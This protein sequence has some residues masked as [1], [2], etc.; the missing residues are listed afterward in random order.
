[1][2]SISKRLEKL[3]ASSGIRKGRSIIIEAA[4]DVADEEIDEMLSSHGLTRTSHDQTI[5]FQ[6][7][8]P[9]GEVMDRPA[10]RLVACHP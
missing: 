8:A 4:A 3:E 5:I 6:I 9:A 10:P 2:Q 1:M 7:V